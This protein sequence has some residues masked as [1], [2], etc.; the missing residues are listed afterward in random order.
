VYAKFQELEQ[1][2]KLSIRGI[3]VKIATEFFK[4]SRGT[5]TATCVIEDFPTKPGTYKDFQVLLC[6]ALMFIHRRAARCPTD[7]RVGPEVRHF[8]CQLAHYCRRGCDQE[9]QVIQS[10]CSNISSVIL[11]SN[12]ST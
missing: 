1:L 4:K 8:L 11:L 12:N 5:M 9:R 2:L 6:H 10:L 7:G 3:P